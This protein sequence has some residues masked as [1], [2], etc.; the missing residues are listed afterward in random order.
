MGQKGLDPNF[1][2]IYSNLPWAIFQI[3]KDLKLTYLNEIGLKITGFR[4]QDIS[5]G[6]HL[7]DLFTPEDISR[8]KDNIKKFI[9]TGDVSSSEYTVVTKEGHHVPVRIY[10]FP[11]VENDTLMELF[12]I[13]IDLREERKIQDQA[14]EY[15]ITLEKEVEKRTLQLSESEKKYRELAEKMNDIVW[16]MDMGLNLKYVSPSITKILGYTVEE[17][18]TQ[19]F[20]KQITPESMSKIFETLSRE[21]ELEKD[22]SQDPDRTIR[23][24]SDYYH[25]DGS[26][27]ILENVIGGVRNDAGTL[28]GFHGVS[29]DITERRR[30]ES[31]IRQSEEEKSIILDTTSDLITLRDLDYNITWMNKAEL[32]RL[33]LSLTDVIGKKCYEVGSNLDTM[34]DNCLASKVVETG[35]GAR[36]TRETETGIY[37]IIIEPVLDEKGNIVSILD[38]TRNVTQAVELEREREINKLKTK[39]MSTASHEIKTPLT[40]IL[41]YMELIDEAGANDDR[42]RVMEYYSVLRRNAVR[43]DSLVSDLL[44]MQ[45]LEVDRL[46]LNKTRFKLAEFMNSVLEE[47]K[48]LYFEKRVQIIT[49]IPSELTLT[50]DKE[51]IRQV[52]INL[53]NNAVKF[54]KTGGNIKLDIAP[55]EKGIQFVVEDHGIGLSMEDMSKLFTPFPDIEPKVRGK[56]TGLGLSIC[57]G[58]IELHNG[59]IMAESEGLGQGSTFT[60][61][62]PE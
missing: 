17:R 34:C 6:L 52:V 19:P 30:L 14:R 32:D 54:S 16:T 58:I 37:D 18:Y 51:R 33:G 42:D 43:L 26:I 48:P 29:R 25:K 35:E 10:H 22:P 62:I 49:N 9:E 46:V 55:V 4:K 28:I 5:N 59:S 36:S 2:N 44:D 47:T 38:I 40:S 15:S 20:D 11:L 57:K 31:I 24:E 3:D 21:L 27:R 61:V 41:G 45:R 60:F 8:A 7:E 13:A 1:D 23:L 50:A 56:G 12:G 39:F 53:L